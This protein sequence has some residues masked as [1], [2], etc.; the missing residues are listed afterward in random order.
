MIYDYKNLKNDELSSFKDALYEY[1]DH[2]KLDLIIELV[3]DEKIKRNIRNRIYKKIK[4]KKE[5][6]INQPPEAIKYCDGDSCQVV[7]NGGGC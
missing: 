3:F 2:D 5:K 6:N 4:I 1:K 7:F